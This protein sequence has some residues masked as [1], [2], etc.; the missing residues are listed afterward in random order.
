MGA[1]L[2][3][4]LGAPCAA[5]AILGPLSVVL[6]LGA[7]F[8]SLGPIM[9]MLD[10]TPVRIPLQVFAVLGAGINLYVIWYASR[11]R[12]K[13]NNAPQLTRWERRK[14]WLVV[15]LSVFSLLSVAFEMYAHV[16]IE[17]MSLL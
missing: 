10:S 8:G 11:Q 14:V 9:H 3:A 13:L 6:G 17:G 2:F 12:S 1:A 4:I 15:G 16:F 5:T 7:A